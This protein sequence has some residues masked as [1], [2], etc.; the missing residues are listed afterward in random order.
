MEMKE[1]AK[2]RDEREPRVLGGR[3]RDTRQE[4]MRV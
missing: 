4:G 3:G 2:G 1:R